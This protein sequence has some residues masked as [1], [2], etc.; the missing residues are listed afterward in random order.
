MLPGGRGFI[1]AISVAAVYMPLF[2]AHHVRLIVAGH[3]HLYD[4][5]VEP[6]D[7]HGVTHRIDAVVTGGG[8]APQYPYGG[9]PDLTDYLAAGAAQNVRVEHVVTP[10]PIAAENP[11]HFVIFQVDGEQLSLEVVGI[12][13]VPYR[14]Y[15]GSARVQLNN[16]GS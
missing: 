9:E 7:D 3:D 8:G 5:F 14:P 1:A 6:Y 4:H 2:R 15:D 10:S 13:A 11:H 12:G 16:R